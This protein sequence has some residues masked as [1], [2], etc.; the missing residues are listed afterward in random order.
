[1]QKEMHPF[2]RWR[3]L[4]DLTIRE[5]AQQVG[6]GRPH[7]SEI[8][9]S[10]KTPSFDLAERLCSLTGGQVTLGDFAR[11]RPGA[12]ADSAPQSTEA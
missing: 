8:E 1:M 6:C 2:K 3:R 4:A 9:N 10:R 12:T 5:V 11:H 7:L